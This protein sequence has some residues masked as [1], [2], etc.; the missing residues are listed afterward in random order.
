MSTLPTPKA[1]DSLVSIS[2]FS[3]GGANKIFDE[4]NKSGCKIVLK[5][6]TP[7]CILISPESYCTLMTELE[8]LRLLKLVEERIANDNG[9]TIPA[10]DVY[11]NL[12]I[13]D[14]KGDDIPME[15]GVD[16]E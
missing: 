6:N 4:V 8:E 3:K 5:N 1:L 10:D 7:T 12:G 13:A 2:S 9:V 14:D 16:F 15:Y 11:L